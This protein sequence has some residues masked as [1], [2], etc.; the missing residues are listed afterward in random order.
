MTNVHANPPDYAKNPNLP[1]TIIIDTTDLVNLL[2]ALDWE[3]EELYGLG[4]VGYYPIH[5]KYFP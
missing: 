5:D 1:I 4:I 2:E 3:Y